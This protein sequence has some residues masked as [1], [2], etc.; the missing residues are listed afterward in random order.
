M[1]LPEEELGIESECFALLNRYLINSVEWLVHSR[2]G[3]HSMD[4]TYGS[5]LLRGTISR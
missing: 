4:A 3:H 2:K 1:S 5:V